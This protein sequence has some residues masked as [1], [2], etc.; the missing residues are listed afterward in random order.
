MKK[1]LITLVGILVVLLVA[2]SDKEDSAEQNS[3]LTKEDLSAQNSELIKE[4]PPIEK[5]KLTM[6]SF[7][8]AFENEGI[9]VNIDDKP[10]YS[11]IYADDGVI[12]YIDNDPVK[13]YEYATEKDIEKGIEALPDMKNWEKNGRFVLETTNEKAKEI[14]KN[15]K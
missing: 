10:M 15:V 13:I 1:Y 8:D 3:E 7:I 2:C 6:Q 14:F 11:I 4:N 12:F 9:E 5:S